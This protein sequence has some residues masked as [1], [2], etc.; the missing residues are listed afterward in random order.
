M[1]AT[2]ASIIYGLPRMRF[3]GLNA[4]PYDVAGFNF[5]HSHGVR[6][7]PYVD[8]EAFEWTGLNS[9]RLPF[10]LY[11]LNTLE[12]DLF[13][14]AWNSWWKALANGEPGE[15]VHPLLG[16]VQAVVRDGDVQLVAQVISG[17]VVHVNFST[18]I[19]DPAEKRPDFTVKAKAAAGRA[20]DADNAAA[21]ASIPYPADMPGPSLLD[22]VKQIDGLLFLLKNEALGVIAQVQGV[23]DFMVTFIDT[24]RPDH[25]AIHARDALVSLWVSLDA[26]AQEVGANTA[27]KTGSETLKSPTTLEAFARRH[28][29]ALADIVEL[30]VSAIGA[31]EVP[32]GATLKFYVSP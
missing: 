8:G 26:L 2:P 19:K 30:N 20:A 9:K 5:A 18:A 4:P 25:F 27:R 6:G 24:N 10:T 31:P 32:A 17:I 1:V 28:G 29:N 3:R 15:L 11:F 14:K 16:P 21:A 22:M 7:Y 13:P 12:P 23:I